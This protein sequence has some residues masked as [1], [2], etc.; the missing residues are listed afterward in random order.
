MPVLWE[1][2]SLDKDAES[3]VEMLAVS[4]EAHKPKSK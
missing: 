2:A 1:K 4:H 3:Y